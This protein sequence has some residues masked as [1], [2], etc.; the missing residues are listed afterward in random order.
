MLIHW[1]KMKTIRGIRPV[2]EERPGPRPAPWRRPDQDPAVAPERLARLVERFGE[3]VR[4][5]LPVFRG[6]EA[7]WVDREHVVEVCRHLRDVEEMDFLTD[8][9][10]VHTPDREHLFEVVIHL[11]SSTRNERLRLK[12]PLR[13]GE[14]M[15][16]L[17]S[18]WEGANWHEREAHDLVGVPF[19]GH[20]DLR[21]ILLPEGFDGHPLQKDFP[22][23]G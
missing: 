11:Y 12:V 9:C 1:L 10:A 3:S 23:K 2:P 22:L 16:S 13:T 20:P 15:P 5:I 19:R 7:G 18:V 6:E 21:R 17:T 8:L 14:S 4:P